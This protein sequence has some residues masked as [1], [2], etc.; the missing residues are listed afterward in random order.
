MNVI[1]P[2]RPDGT[3]HGGFGQD[4]L[5]TEISVAAI[6]HVETPGVKVHIE[7][8][9]A[10]LL[11]REDLAEWIAI[12]EYLLAPSDQPVVVIGRVGVVL[13]P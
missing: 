3:V 10:E 6:L 1:T 4:P 11:P 12:D 5:V 2:A 7:G 9:T 13:V 8:T